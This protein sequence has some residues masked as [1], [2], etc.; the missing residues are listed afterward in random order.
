MN[1][2]PRVVF[3]RTLKDASWNNTTLVKG[4][5]A[6]ETQ[7]LKR[8][9]GPDLVMFGSGSVV[10]QLAQAGLVDEYQLVVNPV[11]LGGGRTMFDGIKEKLVL[12]LTKWRTFDNGSVF[13]CYEPTA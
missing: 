11:V 12:K 4:D 6:S 5:L 9:S 7:R 1:R 13:A 3:S 8:E 10:S 2:L